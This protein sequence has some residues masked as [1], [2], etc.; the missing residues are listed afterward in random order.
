MPAHSRAK[1]LVE[2]AEETLHTYR[3]WLLCQEL[4]ASVLQYLLVQLGE[5]GCHDND[6]VVRRVTS[7]A[8]VLVER[9]AMTMVCYVSFTRLN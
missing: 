8:L 3:L 7:A 4:A 2:S 5:Q 6:P 1:S 9:H